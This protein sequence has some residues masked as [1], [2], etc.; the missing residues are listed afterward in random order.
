MKKKIPVVPTVLLSAAVLLLAGST[1]GSTRAALTY[2]SE[3]YSASVN[4][5]QIGVSIEENGET[6]S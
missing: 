2:F 1:V 4:I 5:S 6:V 3:N